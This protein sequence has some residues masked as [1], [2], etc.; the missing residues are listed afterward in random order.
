MDDKNKMPQV[1]L[2]KMLLNYSHINEN[3]VLYFKK[4]IDEND[5]LVKV[6]LPY[7]LVLTDRAEI[8][9]HFLQKNSK[10][11]IKTALVRKT[12][13]NQIGNGLFTSNGDYWLKQRRA[14]QP[15]FCKP[16]LE[17]I[18]A[19]MV[20]EINHY[21]DTVLDTYVETNE[22]IN[23]VDL[24]GDLAFKVITKS[25]FGQDIEDQ[26]L[27]TIGESISNSQEY[28]MNQARKPYL[29]PWYYINGATTENKRL[30]KVREDIIIGFIEE[31]KQSGK[32]VDDLLDML[33]ETEYEDGSKMTNQQLLDET[34]VLLIAGHETSAITMSWAWYLLCEHPE[35]EDQL[36]DS[37][38]ENLGDKDPSFQNA[39]GLGYA[40]QVLEESMR[41][42]PAVWFIDREPLE[43]DEV[44]GVK[45]KK[46]EDIG[47]FIYGLHRNPAYWENP[48]T[49]DPNRFSAENKKNHTPHSFLPFGGGPRLCIGKNFA[50]MQMQFIFAMLI[51]RYKFVLSPNQVIDFKPLLT[52]CPSN[53]IKIRIEKRVLKE[54]SKATESS[55]AVVY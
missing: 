33:L 35:I 13:R 27:N 42:Y 32:K 5:G 22:E 43:D 7:S 25:L 15:G 8:I 31:R 45:I 1:G 12:V 11:Y 9:G 20:E 28:V 29:K 38:M 51:K 46:G 10:N 16:K 17:A 52:L 23:L 26:K 3:L 55:G 30:K 21:M 4:L 24:M 37:V 47:A 53:G 40:L 48:D 6:K 39:R 14:I 34:I 44:E 41:L 18:T 36:L 49:F 2:A 19:V 50:Q 54:T